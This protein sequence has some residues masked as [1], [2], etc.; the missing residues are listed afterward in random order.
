LQKNKYKTWERESPT[1]FFPPFLP[2]KEVVFNYILNTSSEATSK[3]IL[4][5]PKEV[6]QILV[7]GKRKKSGFP[8]GAFI[9][10]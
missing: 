8:C 7:R 2:P 5:P 10:K 1:A 6:W 3:K 4:L 9:Y